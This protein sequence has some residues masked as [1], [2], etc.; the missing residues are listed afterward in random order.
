MTQ[1]E[2]II[3]TILTDLHQRKGV[4]DELDAIDPEIYKEMKG[5]LIAKVRNLL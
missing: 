3:Q 1:A 5:E 2:L 4:G